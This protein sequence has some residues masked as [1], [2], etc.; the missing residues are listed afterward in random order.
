MGTPAGTPQRRAAPT[1]SCD[2]LTD[3]QYALGHARQHNVFCVPSSIAKRFVR[4]ADNAPQVMVKKISNNPKATQTSKDGTMVTMS[5]LEAIKTFSRNNIGPH[6]YGYVRCDDAMLVLMQK[7]P[8]T[9]LI[10]YMAQHRG[11]VPQHVVDNI[12]GLIRHMA[13]AGLYHGDLNF[14]NIFI[15]PTNIIDFGITSTLKY[16]FGRHWDDAAAKQK[17]EDAMK[18]EFDRRLDIN[19][20]KFK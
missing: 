4:I 7:L 20:R 8:G 6:I 17:M 15:G 10:D 1:P 19:A 2:A 11:A 16:D 14:D 12:Y 9:P 18:R 13:Q 3:P 5:E